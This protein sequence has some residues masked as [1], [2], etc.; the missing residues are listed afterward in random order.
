MPS[1]KESIL[2]ILDSFPDDI[3]WE[4]FSYALQIWQTVQKGLE[5]VAAGRTISTDQLKERLG[6]P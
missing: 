4:D 6:L 1:V 3:T 5:D 2:K